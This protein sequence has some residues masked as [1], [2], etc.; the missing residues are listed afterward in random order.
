MAERLKVVIGDAGSLARYPQGGGHWAVFVQYVAG[1]LQL[2]HDVLLLEVAASTDHGGAVERF[3]TNAEALGI[4]DHVAVLSYDDDDWPPDLDQ[5]RVDGLPDAHLRRWVADAD[6][7]LN[8]CGWIRPP[9][10]GRFRRK[11]LLDLDPGHLQ[12]TVSPDDMAVDEHAA[13]LTV[14]LNV[15]GSGCTVPTFGVEWQTFAPFVHLPSWSAA[16]S[17]PVDA[18]FASVTHW[19]WGELRLDDGTP[20]SLSKRDAYL[21]HVDLPR[22][23]GRPFQ[24][25]VNLGD[26]PVQDA[27]LLET[28]GWTVVDPWVVADSVASY[29]DYIASCR[30]EIA[31]A[32]P[33]F[34]DLCT[35]WFSDR[36]VCF[37][38]SGRPVVAEDTGF[39]AWLPHGEGLLA[40]A[41]TDEA[42]EAVRAVDAD[43]ERHA[44]AARQLAEDTFSSAIWLPRMLDCA[45]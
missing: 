37:L 40:F 31:C 1:L 19:N 18:P 7:L 30:A 6:L 43:Y 13:F 3:L 9:L 2:G 5:C 34:R 45:A 27:A 25:A 39:T 42:V 4:A 23:A 22:R 24:L 41:D 38:A 15:G 11:A 17:A 12:L 36:S 32:K 44:R 10:L 33:V 26:D 16:P 20:V 28:N 35:G 21:R 14:G 8:V 29:A